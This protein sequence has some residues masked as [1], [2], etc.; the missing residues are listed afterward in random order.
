MIENEERGKRVGDKILSHTNKLNRRR[1]LL[2]VS[3]VIF[4]AGHLIIYL[5]LAKHD[6]AVKFSRPIN[7][8]AW[9]TSS[10]LINAWTYGLVLL[11]GSIVMISVLCLLLAINS[12][13]KDV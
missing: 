13:L 6:I 12:W 10:E 8:M 3:A 2:M 5:G 4:L 11:G 7:S 1:L 9:T